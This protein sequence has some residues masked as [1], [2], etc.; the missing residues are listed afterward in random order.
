MLPMPIGA[1]AKLTYS[2]NESDN[3]LANERPHPLQAV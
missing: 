3:I 2:V 1:N